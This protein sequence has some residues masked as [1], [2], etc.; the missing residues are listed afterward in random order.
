[1]K[2]KTNFQRVSS[3]SRTSETNNL[4]LMEKLEAV[5]YKEK[6]FDI[7]K[8]F[9]EFFNQKNYTKKSI[10]DKEV[11]FLKND[12]TFQILVTSSSDVLNEKEREKTMNIIQENKIY[13]LL[14]YLTFL[15]HKQKQKMQEIEENSEDENLERE[16][17]K[18]NFS[19]YSLQFDTFKCEAHTFI[20]NLIKIIIDS[21]KMI[22]SCAE[23]IEIFEIHQHINLIN[24]K[25]RILEEKIQR[26]DCHEQ[27]DYISKIIF[28]INKIEYFPEGEYSFIL[29]Y[30][31]IN[32]LGRMTK[33]SKLLSSKKKIKLTVPGQSVNLLHLNLQFKD[34]SYSA[35]EIKE[36]DHKYLQTNYKS[37]GNIDRMDF[38]DRETV[39]QDE[40][41][42]KKQVFSEEEGSVGATPDPTPEMEEINDDNFSFNKDKRNTKNINEDNYRTKTAQPTP[43]PTQIPKLND[44]FNINDGTGTSLVY[45]GLKVIKDGKDFAV[46][47][48]NFVDLMLLNL[49]E[50]LDLNKNS[51]ITTYKTTLN[52]LNPDSRYDI[53]YDV[54][55]GL[56]VDMSFEIRLSLLKRIH[57]IFMANISLKAYH[58]RV[59]SEI[60]DGYFPEISDKVRSILN[61]KT[62]VK[63]ACCDKCIIF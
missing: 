21:Q 17:E 42:G 20:S 46:S 38:I 59:I 22:D 54:T 9:Q 55:L 45:F 6:R 49:D 18:F 48:E 30:N 62:E 41:I 15:Y 24:Q 52:E 5:E 31:E 58:E 25:I 2:L 36:V 34:I 8:L 40:K 10:I 37:L 12:S 47:S 32:S 23:R 7:E 51:I 19:T 11:W 56:R 57:E 60:I 14:H 16:E 28:Y 39:R 26:L 53:E 50:L 43:T 63:E 61:P 44:K 4:K 29:K 3:F 1:M 33:H 27:R 13:K 35:I